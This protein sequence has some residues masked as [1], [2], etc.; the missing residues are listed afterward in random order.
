MVTRTG[1]A[2]Q[3]GDSIA[4]TV[5]LQLEDDVEEVTCQI[6]SLLKH[7]ETS[8]LLSSEPIL[9]MNYSHAAE[10]SV[11]LFSDVVCLPYVSP[12]EASRVGNSA[13]ISYWTGLRFSLGLEI[14]YPD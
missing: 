6:S 9:K 1:S 13:S 4:S 3:L 12:P 10:I 8:R 11:V 5:P 2:G 14:R 7:S